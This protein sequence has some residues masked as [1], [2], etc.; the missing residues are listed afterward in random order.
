MFIGATNSPISLVENPEFKELVHVLDSRYQVPTRATIEKELN[1]VLIEMKG[2][3]QSYMD[4]ARLVNVCADIWT[5]RGMTASF[6]GVTAHFFS[7]K[8]HKRHNVTLA[9]RSMASPHTILEEW[10]LP[11]FKI[12]CILTDNGSNMVAAFKKHHHT[13]HRR[14]TVNDI[15]EQQNELEVT[16]ETNESELDEEPEDENSNDNDLSVPEEDIQEYEDQ[17]SEHDIVFCYYKRSSCF[18]HTLQL[19]VRTFDQN[20]ASISMMN[21]VHKL[22]S[23]VNKSAKATESLLKMPSEIDF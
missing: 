20:S 21:T 14:E 11:R 5:K 1:K 22:V 9:V 16:E 13:D 2:N 18:A 6:L 15:E 7:F 4:Q 10:K 12:H 17:E 3:I 23:K 19:V 8:D